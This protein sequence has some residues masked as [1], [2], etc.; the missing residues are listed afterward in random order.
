M[1][2][3]KVKMRIKFHEQYCNAIERGKCCYKSHFTSGLCKSHYELFHLFFPQS[4]D[5]PKNACIT[6]EYEMNPVYRSGLCKILERQSS[7]KRKVC[8]NPLHTKNFCQ[9]HDYILT[10]AEPLRDFL[11]NL[12]QT[13]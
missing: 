2:Y 4:P 6:L 12:P 10:F 5:I 7:I 1:K 11:E 9:Q 3:F 8:H 13:R